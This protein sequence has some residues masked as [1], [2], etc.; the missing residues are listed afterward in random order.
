MLGKTPN[1]KTLLYYSYINI[2]FK[3]IVLSHTQNHSGRKIG[4][5]TNFVLH[6]LSWITWQKKSYNGE[7][8]KENP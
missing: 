3:Y 5:Q 2:S 4:G 8:K 7:K 6:Q 1:H